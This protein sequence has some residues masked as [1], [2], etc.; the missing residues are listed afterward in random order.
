MLEESAI[1]LERAVADE[2]TKMLERATTHESA[3]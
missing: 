1:T 3:K 2:T